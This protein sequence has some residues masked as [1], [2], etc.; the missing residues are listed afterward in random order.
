MNTDIISL[1]DCLNDYED[2]KQWDK[3]EYGAFKIKTEVLLKLYGS[4]AILY[5]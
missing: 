2:M 5:T 3:D 4:S 1:V